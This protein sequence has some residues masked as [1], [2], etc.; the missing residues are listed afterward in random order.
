M[1][2]WVEDDICTVV[3][4]S[5][6]YI[7]CNSV[8]VSQYKL[9]KLKLTMTAWKWTS[10][11]LTLHGFKKMLTTE[12]F[13]ESRVYMLIFRT[14]F[15]IFFKIQR[16]PGEFELWFMKKCQKISWHCHFKKYWYLKNCLSDDNQDKIDSTV[17]GSD[18]HFAFQ[19][20]LC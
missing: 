7:Y 10:H 17:S 5:V 2:L 20:R 15:E 11:W 19:Q 13:L 16:G 9:R 8:G 18:E 12:Y 4:H 14:I 6:I 3:F 1:L